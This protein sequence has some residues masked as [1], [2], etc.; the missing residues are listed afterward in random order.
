[1]TEDRIRCVICAKADPAAPATTCRGCL[2]RIDDDL[3]AIVVL[4]RAATLHLETATA[5]GQSAGKPGSRPPLDVGA[6]DDS[7]ASDALPMLESW[8]RLTRE[9]FNLAP[10]GMASA[11]RLSR[12]ASSPALALGGVV[13][14]LRGWLARIAETPDFPIEVLAGE[15]GAARGALNRYDEDRSGESAWTLRCPGDHPDAD[16]RPCGWRLRMV[17]GS[18]VVITCRQCS[19]AW[20]PTSLLALGLST[21][22]VIFA[23]PADIEAVLGISAATLRQWFH[24]GLIERYGSQYDI[25]AV[26]RRAVG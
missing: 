11:M 4:T 17:P 19:T 7:L 3:A 16:G 9:H 1:M 21:V 18:D 15:V 24:R 10:Y 26:A 14:F 22:D 13:A 12:G 25:G 23:Y 5:P 6:L 20:T 2:N 8:E